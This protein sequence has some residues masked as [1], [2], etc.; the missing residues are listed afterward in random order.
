MKSIKF[1]KNLQGDYL[2]ARKALKS[3]IRGVLG[4]NRVKREDAVELVNKMLHYYHKIG[5][6]MTL[7][8]HF[9]HHH[10]DDFLQQLPTESDEQGERFHHVTMPMEKRYKGKKL[11]SLL[12]EVCWW[13]HKLLIHEQAEEIE[14]TEDCK[15][16]RPLNPFARDDQDSDSDSDSDDECEPQRKKLCQASSS[17]DIDS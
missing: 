6:S 11:D 4:K 5:A 12:A 2:E 1:T 3:V 16:G 10:L 7:K 17:M 9:L 8:L 14:E 15:R 13:S